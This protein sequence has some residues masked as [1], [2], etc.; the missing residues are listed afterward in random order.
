MEN[1]HCQNC[2]WRLIEKDDWFIERTKEFTALWD[3]RGQMLDDGMSHVDCAI[4]FKN[5]LWKM[6]KE[7]VSWNSPK[8]AALERMVATMDAAV[9]YGN[10]TVAGWHLKHSGEWVK[11]RE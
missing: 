5:M 9:A 4:Y 8:L 1:K 11:I 3:K 7:G 2:E 6:G 10:Y